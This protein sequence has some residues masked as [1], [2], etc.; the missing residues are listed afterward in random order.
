MSFNSAI[1]AAASFSNL[2]RAA[3]TD[4]AGCGTPPPGFPPRPPLLGALSLGSS[5]LDRVALNPQ[6]L[7]PRE[8]ASGLRQSGNVMDEQ[9]GSVPRWV[10]HLPPPPPL[11]WADR[12]GQ[13]LG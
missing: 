8:V 2:A 9:C 5:V 7:P 6:P 4:D 13:A 11:P 12:A 1:S 3:F 10:H